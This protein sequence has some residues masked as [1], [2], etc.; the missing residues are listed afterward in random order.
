MPRA[1]FAR[2]VRDFQ[3]SPSFSV[4]ALLSLCGVIAIQA[5]STNQIAGPVW[6]EVEY[7]HMAS[8]F[9]NLS[10]KA[11]M[12]YRLF[13]AKLVA[14]LP[15]DVTSGFRLLNWFFLCLMTVASVIWL[16]A[17]G[18]ALARAAAAVALLMATLT[19]KMTIFWTYGTDSTAWAF[20][21]LGLI[22]AESGAVV[23][24]TILLGLGSLAREATA[25]VF[26]VLAVRV[27]T[28]QSLTTW[29]WLALAMALTA[30][31]LVRIGLMV[32][33][34][35]QGEYSYIDTMVACIQAHFWGKGL[36]RT[37]LLLPLVFGMLLWPIILDAQGSLQR[38]R[39]RWD[40]TLFGLLTMLLGLVGGSAIDRLVFAAFPVVL[41]L[42]ATSARIPA[43]ALE[44]C[45]LAAG[46]LV[47]MRLWL[48]IPDPSSGHEFYDLLVGFAALKPLVLRMLLFLVFGFLFGVAQQL[49]IGQ[50]PR[51]LS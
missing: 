5:V 51:T 15:F 39:E 6:E 9:G 7:I 42:F 35:V 48:H 41:W 23:S 49:R 45:N 4:L 29:R 32:A 17:L 12:A 27:S 31:V 18:V 13:P 28:E 26:V 43:T 1:W 33:I 16:H 11:P 50:G 47:L 8:A 34:P 10:D 25:L 37:A 36:I 20:Q 44:W 22:A 2:V 30:L 46:Q 40:L 3:Q 14:A 19:I 24:T 21:V 38:M